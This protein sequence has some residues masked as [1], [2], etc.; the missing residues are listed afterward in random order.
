MLQRTKDE[1]HG[2]ISTGKEANANGS[3]LHGVKASAEIVE[4]GLLRNIWRWH[5]ARGESGKLDPNA[6]AR[7]E[8]AYISQVALFQATTSRLSSCQSSA[9]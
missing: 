7:L 9:G 6:T 3:V 8:L 1:I 2:C 5:R 4:R